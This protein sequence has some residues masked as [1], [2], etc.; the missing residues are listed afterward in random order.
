MFIFSLHV[1]VSS[2]TFLHYELPLIHTCSKQ[3]LHMPASAYQHV[4][5]HIYT[6]Q[7]HKSGQASR[8]LGPRIHEHHGSPRGW[9]EWL[10]SR[11]INSSFASWNSL[12]IARVIDINTHSLSSPSLDEKD[13]VG[14]CIEDVQL[15]QA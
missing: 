5:W 15:R 14:G 13:P 12:H 2:S 10:A 9:L 4:N 3:Y 6:S 7:V 11:N 8:T 1:H